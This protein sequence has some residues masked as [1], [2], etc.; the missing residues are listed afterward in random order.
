MPTLRHRVFV[1]G[2][3]LT[4]ERNHYLMSSARLL[5]AASTPPLY[6]L[7]DLEDYPAL[8][9]NGETV[10]HG[11]VYEIDEATLERLDALEN[12]PDYYQ[13]REISLDDGSRAL[14]YLLPRALAPSASRIESGRWAASREPV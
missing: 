3:L 11:E 2:T 10:V 4:G 7:L 8:V 9:A 5:G 1:Y 6:D 12:H 14:A 13:R